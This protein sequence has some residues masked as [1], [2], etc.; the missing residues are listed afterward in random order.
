M[1]IFKLAT[2]VTKD[3]GALAH[4]VLSVLDGKQ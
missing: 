2:S 3:Q 4:G 1:A